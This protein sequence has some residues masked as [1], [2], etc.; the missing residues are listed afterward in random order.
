MRKQFTTYLSIL[1]LTLLSFQ[2]SK[3]EFSAVPNEVE[4]VE[5]VEVVDVYPNPAS[6]YVYLKFNDAVATKATI[7][8]R[9]VIGNKMQVDYF[10]EDSHLI[11]IDINNIPVGH[12]YA[13]I[14]VGSENTIKKFI[15]R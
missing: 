7:E 9:S 4:S 2:P 5:V 10:V 14:K 8:L 1:I 11:K 3:A 6:D 13:I 12:Y 15:K